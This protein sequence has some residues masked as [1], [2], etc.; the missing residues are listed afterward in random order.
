MNKLF[1][2]LCIVNFVLLLVYSI[3]CYF[4]WSKLLDL[5]LVATVIWSPFIIQIWFGG[6]V[7]VIIDGLFWEIN[8]SFAIMLVTMILNLGVVWRIKK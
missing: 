2:R 3:A 8:W 5:P 6:T 7:P 1:L 4:E